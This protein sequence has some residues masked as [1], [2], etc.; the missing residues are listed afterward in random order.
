[1]DT[2][3]PRPRQSPPRLQRHPHIA[4]GLINLALLLQGQGKFAKAEP[5]AR[6]AIELNRASRAARN[7]NI[8]AGLSRLANV[9]QAL[10][11]IP[12]ARAGWDEAIPMLRKN[13]PNGSALRSRVLWRSGS[14]R[15]ENKDATA[16]LPELE[17]AAAMAEKFVKPEG[18]QLKEYRQTLAKCKAAVAARGMDDAQGDGG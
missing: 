13:S 8:A 6:E 12:E 3:M 4:K 18:K 10:G 17:E 11:K 5:L 16:A 1:M 14:T 15:L 9:Q 2:T 7:E